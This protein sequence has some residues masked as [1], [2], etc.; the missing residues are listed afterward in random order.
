ME[1][2]VVEVV[3]GLSSV[4]MWAGGIVAAGAAGGVKYIHGVAVG[5]DKKADKALTVSA[6][7]KESVD[8]IVDRLDKIY[9]I[10][11]NKND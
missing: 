5:A 11:I 9:I 10:L 8:R 6:I 1:Q 7:N 3:K 2:T 4:V